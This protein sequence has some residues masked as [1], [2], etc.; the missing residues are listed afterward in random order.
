[1]VRRNRQHKVVVNFSRLNQLR[2]VLLQLKQLLELSLR[3]ELLNVV[4]RD[5]TERALV[6]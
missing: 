6:K 2:K 5:V 3:K 1:M 4:F